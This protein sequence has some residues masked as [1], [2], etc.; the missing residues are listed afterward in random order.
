MQIKIIDIVKETLVDH[1]GH[2]IYQANNVLMFEM[3]IP[4]AVE[5]QHNTRMLV[6]VLIPFAL[7]ENYDTLKELMIQNSIRTND[8]R[9]GLTDIAGEIRAY[10]LSW[11]CEYEDM[12]DTIERL[13]AEARRTLVHLSMRQERDS[14][15]LN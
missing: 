11:V 4:I 12:V 15:C 8:C 1:Y 14:V 2:Q 10:Q 7:P 6:S 5:F 3:G 13:R 9:Y